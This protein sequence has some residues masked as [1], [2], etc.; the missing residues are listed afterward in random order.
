MHI[1]LQFPLNVGLIGVGGGGFDPTTT[2]ALGIPLILTRDFTN[3][4]VCTG[5]TRVEAARLVGDRM[6]VKVSVRSRFCFRLETVQ[7]S[8][9]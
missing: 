4:V 2:Q 5:I 9:L 7:F 3:K 6:F 8:L 1:V